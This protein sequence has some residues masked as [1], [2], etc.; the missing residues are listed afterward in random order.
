MQRR[1]FLASTSPR[2]RE[3]VTRLNLPFEFLSVDVDESPLAEESP[4]VMVERLALT[5]LNSARAVRPD[6]ILVSADTTVALDDSILGKPE[7][8]SDAARML[9]L[10]RGRS[11]RV[12]TGV[13]VAAGSRQRVQT[14]ETVVWMR[15]YSDAEIESYVATGDPLDKAAAYAIQHPNFHPVAR[16]DGC[17]ANVMGLPLCRV[18]LSLREF[19]VEVADPEP[20][21]RSYLEADCPAAHSILDNLE[22]S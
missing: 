17:Y 20:L 18:Y 12:F 14:A 2:R 6:A 13:A 10:L 15:E 8:A 5:K 4:R 11:H 3:L 19:G 22:G 1:L 16:I 21:F 9:R 7:N